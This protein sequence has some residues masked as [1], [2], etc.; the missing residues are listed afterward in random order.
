[1][2]I[3]KSFS[4][5]QTSGAYKHAGT[6]DEIKLEFIGK[7]GK[8]GGLVPLKKFLTQDFEKGQTDDFRV[9]AKNVGIPSLIRISKNVFFKC[10]LK[11]IKSLRM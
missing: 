7:N 1:M 4:S 5:F 3:D 6:S 8:S 11:F 10:K 9:M 2:N